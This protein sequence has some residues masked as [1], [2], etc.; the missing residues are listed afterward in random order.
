MDIIK[1]WNSLP[2]HLKML[3]FLSLFRC[4]TFYRATDLKLSWWL[5]LAILTFPGLNFFLLEMQYHLL[6]YWF[7][8]ILLVGLGNTL[9]PVLN[10][11]LARMAVAR[12]YAVRHACF[13]GRVPGWNCVIRLIGCFIDRIFFQKI[14]SF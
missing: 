5:A 13:A 2:V 12:W 9:L 3:E 1:N 10:L 8:T 7:Y 6:R 11:E 4:N 14:T